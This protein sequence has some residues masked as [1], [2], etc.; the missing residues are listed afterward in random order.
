MY[1]ASKKDVMYKI[2]QIA[3]LVYG[4]E[5]PN[6]VLDQLLINPLVGVGLMSNSGAL[7]SCDQL[8]VAE[9]INDLDINILDDLKGVKSH[10]Q[11]SFWFGYY[12]FVKAMELGDKYSID[13]FRKIGESL[14]GVRWQTDMAK[15]L[16]LKDA[17]RIRQWLSS[18]RPIPFGIWQDLAALLKSKQ[19]QI[20]DILDRLTS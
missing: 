19:V 18:D 12:H 4:S 16:G 17:R 7:H 6:N 15:A 13:D 10:I 11:G 5:I 9:L 1:N 14:Y 2:G 20:S 3:R 8:Q